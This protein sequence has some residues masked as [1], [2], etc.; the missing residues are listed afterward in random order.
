MSSV[1]SP[2]T[3]S[4]SPTSLPSAAS[5]FQPARII[6]HE[7]GS[8]TFTVLPLALLT[9]ALARTD[10]Q[11]GRAQ[12]GLNKRGSV[13]RFRQNTTPARPGEPIKR[14]GRSSFRGE[15]GSG[16]APIDGCRAGEA[17]K[18][19]AQAE[20]TIIAR[21]AAGE[22]LR[23]IAPDY[24]VSH[25]AL[26]KRLKRARQRQAQQSERQAQLA[27]EPANERGPAIEPPQPA[28][29]SPTR[30]C[31]DRRPGGAT[32]HARCRAASLRPCGRASR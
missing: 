16:L 18:I 11:L 30:S 24:D 14:S 32:G 17:P 1:S 23:A 19:S 13:S 25:Q 22:P 7:T 27:A 4:T 26:S 9:A 8:P 21:H 31:G 28:G 2:A 3:S 15:N 12:Y 29:R 10:P 20:A 5:T 6:S